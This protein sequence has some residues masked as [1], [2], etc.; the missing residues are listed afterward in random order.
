MKLESRN[1][2]AV[3]DSEQQNEP[4]VPKEKKAV[5]FQ[6]GQVGK[7]EE[8]SPVE[9]PQRTL[10]QN[11]T[12]KQRINSLVLKTLQENTGRER[13]SMTSEVTNNT[14]FW[15]AKLLQNTRVVCSVKECREVVDDIV[16]KKGNRLKLESEDWPFVDGKV[17]IGVDCEG[18]NLGI[19][20]QLTL[21]QIATVTGHV[22]IFD[23]ISCP[24]MMN[25]A[26]RDLF[27]NQNV[28]KVKL[29]LRPPPPQP[30]PTAFVLPQVIHDCKNDS[31]NLYQ[32]FNV[33]LR[34]VFDTQ[35]AHAVMTYQE[36]G[37]PV[38]KVKSVAL[39]ALCQFCEAPINPMKEQLKN[40]YRRDQKFWSRRPLSRDMILYASGDASTLMHDKIYGPMSR[41][42]KPENR[43]LLLDLCHEQVI[44]YLC[45]L[46][47]F[48]KGLFC[49]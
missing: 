35:A 43:K 49:C 28:V 27:E 24:D 20:G 6:L 10:A 39:N 11:Q 23:L 7:E 40:I 15:K 19:K 3:L 21:I 36:T 14:D 4:D 48:L 12:L 44:Y 1:K 26:L 29:P 17:F 38:Y 42:I 37:K 25:S 9:K 41:G 30:K 22:Y 33:T 16:Y 13:H 18:V 2:T 34:G 8:Q 47:V 32:Q 31:I 5:N 46:V 45:D